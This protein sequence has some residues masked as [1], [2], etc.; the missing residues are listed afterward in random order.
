MIFVVICVGMIFFGIFLGISVGICS[1][2]FRLSI[3]TNTLNTDACNLWIVC[4]FIEVC[5]RGVWGVGG[6]VCDH[7]YVRHYWNKSLLIVPNVITISILPPPPPPPLPPPP[8]THRPEPY[9]TIV[10]TDQNHIMH[11]SFQPTRTLYR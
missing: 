4:T 2:A 5:L 9:V 11:S 1:D 7:T 10:T 3:D 8:Y 6:G